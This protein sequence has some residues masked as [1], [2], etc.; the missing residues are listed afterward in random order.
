MSDASL[1]TL[2]ERILKRFSQPAQMARLRTALS[3]DERTSDNFANLFMEGRMEDDDFVR[4][5][6]ET[7]KSFH[8]RALL[9]EKSQG[10]KW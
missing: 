4:Q 8:R 6:K 7:R 10:M 1:H 3:E 9:V 2:T 5:Y